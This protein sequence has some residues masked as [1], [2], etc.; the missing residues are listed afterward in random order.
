MRQLITPNPDIECRPGW[1]LQYV[2]QTYDLPA[3]YNSATEAWEQSDTKHYARDFPGNCWVPVWY[4]VK[5]EPLG[6][7]VLRAPDGSVYSTSTLTNT[8]YHHPTLTHLENFYAYYGMNL[9]YRGWTEDIAGYPV[10]E[11]DNI[12]DESTVTRTGLFMYLTEQQEKD[13]YWQLCTPEGRKAQVDAI[14]DAPIELVDPTGK[15]T[16]VTGTTTL[17]TKIKFMA[18]NDEQIRNDIANLA[19]V[20]GV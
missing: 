3:K 14:L 7:V 13:I 17:R 12:N 8:P 15:T 6:H 9:T 16:N 19:A 10:V 1:C 11:S 2:R 20:H 18:H 5:D 4:E